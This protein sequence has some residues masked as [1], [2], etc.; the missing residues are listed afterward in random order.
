VSKKLYLFGGYD[1]NKSY[2][3]MIVL[4]LESME[5]VHPEVKGEPPVSRNAHTMTS[6]D[7]KL[8]LFGGH[9]GT[10]HLYDLHIYDTA[11][12]TWSQIELQGNPPKVF[13][14]KI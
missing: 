2:N 9:S 12:S 6:Y 1:G 3:E 5:W 13:F 4:D 10:T 14:L 8:L 7:S 11:I